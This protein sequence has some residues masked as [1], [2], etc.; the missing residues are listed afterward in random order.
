MAFLV[1]VRSLSDDRCQHTGVV[2]YL[3]FPWNRVATQE[4]VLGRIRVFIYIK[5]IVV[6]W[7]LWTA[8]HHLLRKLSLPVGRELSDSWG[9]LILIS[10]R[11]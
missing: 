9:A 8:S 6:A 7:Q 3:W 2:L 11:I 1:V 10:G 4:R 5:E